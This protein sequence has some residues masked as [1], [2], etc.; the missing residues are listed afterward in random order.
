VTSK[1]KR[2][3]SV[4]RRETKAVSYQFLAI[5][6]Q[7][8]VIKSNSVKRK[9]R[10]YKMQAV[11]IFR[12]GGIEAL[13]YGEVT[14]PKPGAGEVLVRVKACG[15]NPIDT[16][17][18]RGLGFVAEK[19]KDSLPWVPGYDLSGV[20]EQVGGQV[21]E[22]KPGDEVFGRIGFPKRGG[23]YTEYAVVNPA[24]LVR[25]PANLGHFQAAAVPLA[26]LTAW[27]A[28]HKTANVQKDMRVMVL[29]AAGGVGHFAVQFAKLAGA[30]VTGT[31]SARNSEFIIGSLGCYEFIDYSSFPCSGVIPVM[32]VII[33][34]VGGDA[35][36]QALPLL[37]KDG[38]MVTL[39]TV[40]AAQVIAAASAMGLT[41]RGMVVK[42]DTGDLHAIA[43][44]LTDGLV[45]V[46]VEQA[47]PLAAAARAHEHIEKGHVRGKIVLVTDKAV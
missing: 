15:V 11:Q 9:M 47:Y 27:Q 26:V 7:L 18:R 1:V 39:P 43:N 21:T 19:I 10:D 13:E 4:V 34:A 23:A 24:E 41:A 14:M 44:L 35:A 37:K 45:K 17:I 16:K 42:P 32:D 6:Y 36:I 3:T 31:A 25:K 28:V 33:D 30:Y 8:S 29:A 12:F 20:V 40:T 5:S 22:F 2:E 46:H 38:V